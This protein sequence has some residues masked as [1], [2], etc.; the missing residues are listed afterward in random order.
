MVDVGN[1]HKVACHRVP[2]SERRQ[3]IMGKYFVKRVL[4][5]IPTILLVCIIV[6]ALMR[7]I[8]MDAVATLQQKLECQRKL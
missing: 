6:F 1:N 8:P 2:G 5:L 3:N 7:M 4:L